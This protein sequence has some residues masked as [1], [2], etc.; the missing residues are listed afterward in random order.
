[1]HKGEYKFIHFFNS[2]KIFYLRYS[3]EKIII[4]IIIISRC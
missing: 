4:Q 1:L 3:G 2:I